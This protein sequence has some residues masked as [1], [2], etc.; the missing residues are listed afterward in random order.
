MY[1]IHEVANLFP[2][3]S[4]EEFSSLVED[5]KE[6]G[7]H[8]P[9][10][11]YQ[12]QIIDGRN[13]YKACEQLGIE[14]NVKEWDGQGSI[15]SYVVSLNL[16]RRHLTTSQRSAIYPEMSKL[17]ED[18]ARERQRQ[19]GESTNAKLGRTSSGTLTQKIGEASTGKHDGEAT[20]QASKILGVNRQ[21]LSDAKKLQQDAPE[22]IP[23]MKQ[24]E[25]TIKTA[26]QYASIPKDTRGK[27][28]DNL[29]KQEEGKTKVCTGCGELLP[30][31]K[32]NGAMCGPCRYKKEKASKPNK[33]KPEEVI[34]EKQ[35]WLDSQ[36]STFNSHINQ[37]IMFLERNDN[38]DEIIA[39]GV[40]E[41]E[42][43]YNEAIPVF[44]TILNALQKKIK[45]RRVK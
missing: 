4:D 2:M 6:N 31:E 21:Y 10:T 29:P 42:S 11:I 5:I 7:Q 39:Q 25:I 23:M 27:L 16:K 43:L 8:E 9:I 45:I 30:I 33:S 32:F 20:S 12:N 1:Q 38:L 37:V 26:K 13:R 41:S 17:F 3:M 44:N 18:E 28:L 24:G 14:P 22:L 40:V 36:V 15:T 19:A 34:D 35:E